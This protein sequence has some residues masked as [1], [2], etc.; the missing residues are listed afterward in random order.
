MKI[1]LTP[2]QKRL[3]KGCITDASVLDRLSSLALVWYIVA[4][5]FTEITRVMEQVS[6][7]DW[8]Y[9][10]LLLAWT[11]PAVYKRVIGG[12]IMFVDPKI[13]LQN[14][15]EVKELRTD[16]KIS[17]N[18]QVIVTVLC[19]VIIPWISVLLAYFTTPR[20]FGCRSKYI[21][22]IC[23]IWSFNSSIAYMFHV[24][25]ERNVNRYILI[26]SWFC[27]SGTLVGILLLILSILCHTE[28]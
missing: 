18:I 19:S 23:S 7:G 3:L 8:P 27:L 26:H 16:K 15:I 11:L 21:T 6:K 17:I 14:K 20:G 12:R 24:K 13:G 2:D 22:V 28:T 10:P 9:T 1:I 25:G 4:A 5:I